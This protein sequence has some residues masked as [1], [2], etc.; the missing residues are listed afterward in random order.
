MTMLAVEDAITQ[1]I[2]PH[3]I[4]LSVHAEQYLEY[5]ATDLMLGVVELHQLSPALLQ[6]WS[7]GHSAGFTA[8]LASREGI[9]R[10]QWERDLW[11]FCYSNKKT[12]REYYSHLTS[13]LW[14]EASQ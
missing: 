9:D 7:F 8:G 11:F 6:F 14:L 10:L 4:A 2:Y 5:L 12:P 13:A 3:K 1:T